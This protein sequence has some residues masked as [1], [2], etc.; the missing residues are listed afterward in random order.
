MN[1]E[2][3]YNSREDAGRILADKIAELNL[4]NPYLLAIPRGGIQVAECVSDKL[5]IPINPIVVKKI[6]IPGNPEAGFGAIT[7]DGIKIMDDKAVSYMGISHEAI[8]KISEGIIKEVIHRANVYGRPD[9]EKVRLS[10]VIIID[11][12]VATGYS[13]I[14]AITS[15]KGM[16]P[17][18]ITA[19]VPVAS[20]FAYDKIVHMV[21]NFVCPLVDDTYFF[22]V[23]SYYKE[24]FDLSEDQ[25]KS[26][27]GTSR[28][29][30]K[31]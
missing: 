14:A 29:K 30:Y 12:G 5:K 8:D 13:L 16:K 1:N 6:P 7:E 27:I 22:A 17:V 3:F 19:A 23:A 9:R 26:I 24:W 18:S 21:D 31:F 10:D 28:E 20:K 15:V 4:E 11:D 25:I 2:G